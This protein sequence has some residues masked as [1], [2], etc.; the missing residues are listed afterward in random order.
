M[1]V[2]QNTLKVKCAFQKQNFRNYLWRGTAPPQTSPPWGGGVPSPTPH[3]PRGLRPLSVPPFQKSWIRHCLRLL[4]FARSALCPSAVLPP[5]LHRAAA[6]KSPLYTIFIA[7][8]SHYNWRASRRS[9][10][11]SASWQALY[12]QSDVDN[13][14]YASRSPLLRSA[15]PLDSP[16]ERHNNDA[17][18]RAAAAD[19]NTADFLTP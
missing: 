2:S 3:T 18:P 6:A 19:V 8:S 15:W 9:V 11:R 5:L 1:I 4:V 12:T 16:E 13:V 17:M 14:T 10:G 7:S